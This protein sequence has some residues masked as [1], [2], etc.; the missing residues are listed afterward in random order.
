MPKVMSVP[1]SRKLRQCD[2]QH[3]A[4][5]GILIRTAFSY[6][7]FCQ[8]Y[9]SAS[10]VL[11]QTDVP[12]EKRVISDFNQKKITIQDIFMQ[13]HQKKNKTKKTK[14]SLT[15]RFLWTSERSGLNDWGLSFC[16]KVKSIGTQDSILKQKRPLKILIS[17]FLT[18]VCPRSVKSVSSCFLFYHNGMTFKLLTTCTPDHFAASFS[19]FFESNIGSRANATPYADCRS[20]YKSNFS[21]GKIL[22][23]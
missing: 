10:A 22:W 2:L 19:G 15:F 21:W 1:K 18:F 23:A 17:L 3:Q 9:F 8:K 11:H 16:F 12:L 7:F 4:S 6:C 13:E 14:Y 20:L 5:R